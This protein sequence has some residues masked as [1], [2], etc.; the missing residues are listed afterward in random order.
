MATELRAVPADGLWDIPQACRWLS[1]SEQALR[2]MLRRNQLPPEAIVRIGR[3]I[4]LRS[5]VIRAW[6]KGGEPA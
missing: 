2:T 4:R 3:R 5:D 1:L 6:V